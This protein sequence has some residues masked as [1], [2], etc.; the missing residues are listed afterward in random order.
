MHKDL[1]VQKCPFFENCLQQSFKEGQENEVYLPD[2]SPESFNYFVTWIYS[3]SVDGIYRHGSSE[4]DL[5][6]R[7][8][9]L[10][11]R[12][13][14]LADKLCAAAFQN[15]LMDRIFD[16]HESWMVSPSDLAYVNENLPPSS[17]LKALL[18]AHLGWGLKCP[19][20]TFFGNDEEEAMFGQEL[21][22]VMRDGGDLPREIL[23]AVSHFDHQ[24]GKLPR[25]EERYWYHIHATSEEEKNCEEA[26]ER[27][28]PTRPKRKKAKH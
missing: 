10:A 26:V 15:A 8:N 16:F 25:L 4:T 1:L 17:K 12:T 2:E 28:R 22:K 11:I 27:A 6:F 19:G 24:S 21:A 3:D 5:A 7:H 13:Y 9:S 23:L 18:L 20:H 14:V